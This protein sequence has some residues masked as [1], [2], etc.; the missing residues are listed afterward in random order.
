MSTRPTIKEDFKCPICTSLYVKPA[1]F[2]CGHTMCLSCHCKLDKSSVSPT[3]ETPT[4]KCPLCRYPTTIPWNERPSNIALDKICKLMYPEEYTEIENIESKC[5]DL[6]SRLKKHVVKKVGISDELINLNLSETASKSQCQL[7]E[8]VY[9]KLL[10]IFSRAASQG[11]SYMSVTEA[12]L[13]SEIE[14]C[15]QPLSKKLF[16]NNNVYKLTCTPEECTVYFSKCSMLWGREF[17]NHNHAGSFDST[18][19]QS[20]PPP[21]SRRIMNNSINRIL[22]GIPLT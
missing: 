11:K 18:P 5:A 16:E 9:E 8:R 17:C 4:F 22:L 10:P 2:E 7:A 19:P 13:V 1:V 6:S 21:P 15:I 20:P 14:I 12:T 3:F